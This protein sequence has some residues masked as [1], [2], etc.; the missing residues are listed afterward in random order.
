MIFEKKKVPYLDMLTDVGTIGLQLVGSTVVGLAMGYF[1]DKWLGTDPWLLLLFL[2]LGIVAGFRS[3]YQ[4]ARKIQ[5]RE[6][7][8]LRDARR[9]GDQG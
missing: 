5:D 9:D 3:V 6:N 2:L 1:L 4:E 7:E 8:K